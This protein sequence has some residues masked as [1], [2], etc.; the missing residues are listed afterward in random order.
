MESNP[1]FIYQCKESPANFNHD[2]ATFKVGGRE[3]LALAVREAGGARK[4]GEVW[5]ESREG[6]EGVQG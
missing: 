1:G 5:G 4:T 3:G 2:T 6:P